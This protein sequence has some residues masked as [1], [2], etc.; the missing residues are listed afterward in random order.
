MDGSEVD[1]DG[2]TYGAKLGGVVKRSELFA[3]LDAYM[4]SS[5]AVLNTDNGKFITDDGK[6][7]KEGVDLSGCEEGGPAAMVNQWCEAAFVVLKPDI[8][9]DDD[10]EAEAYSVG[11]R[12]KADSATI[13][14]T[15]GCPAE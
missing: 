4:G 5:C 9:T 1:G 6:C 10:G 7:P 13:V 15:E 12:L 8:D 3:A 2:V 14:G 11:L